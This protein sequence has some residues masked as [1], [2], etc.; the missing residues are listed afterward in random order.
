MEEFTKDFWIRLY[1]SLY[2]PIFGLFF[3][4]WDLYIGGG[5]ER[6]FLKENFRQ[7]RKEQKFCL[8]QS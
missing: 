4:Y 5:K 1:Y 6:I 2:M 7:V 8:L 3:L